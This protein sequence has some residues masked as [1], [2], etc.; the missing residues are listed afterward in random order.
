LSRSIPES[1][2]G[3]SRSRAGLRQRFTFAFQDS[4]RREGQAKRREAIAEYVEGWAGAEI[5]AERRERD[6]LRCYVTFTTARAVA[7]EVAEEFIRECPHVVR[8]TFTGLG[9]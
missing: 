9:G 1:F 8:G 3:S 2:G 7:V 5:V 4:P 6:T